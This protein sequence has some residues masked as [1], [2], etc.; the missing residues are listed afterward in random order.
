LL[1]LAKAPV[2]GRV[3]TRLCP[4]CTPVQAARIAAAALADTLD[5][6]TGTAARTV[7]ALDGRM[8]APPGVAVVRQRGGTLGSRIA[9]AFADVTG[10]GRGPV[11]QIGMDTPQVTPDLLDA[12]LSMLDHDVDAVL[13]PAVD[14]GWWALGLRDP[15]HARLLAGVPMSTPDTGR[16]TVEALCGT[17]L[18]VGTLPM[19]RDVDTWAD[20]VAVAA[21]AP[22]GRLAATVTGVRAGLGAGFAG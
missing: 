14:G 18:R 13:G 9:A 5:A 1:V 20:A 6:A 8:T 15:A 16:L 2:P 3:K 12:G 4:P 11:L 10:G 19:L 22:H 21:L 17:G 7:L